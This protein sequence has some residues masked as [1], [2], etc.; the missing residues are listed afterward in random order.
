V[1]VLKKKKNYILNK[2]G[3]KI[4]VKKKKGRKS[5]YSCPICGWET[6]KIN[7]LFCLACGNS[8]E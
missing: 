2:K 8:F 3:N 7:S 5:R 4:P 1:K 6:K